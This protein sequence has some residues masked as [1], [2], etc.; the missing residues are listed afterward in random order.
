MDESHTRV[1]VEARRPARR[2]AP[3]ID[4]VGFARRVLDVL[5]P[6]RMSVLVRESAWTLEVVTGRQ[7][8][9]PDGWTW[10]EVAIPPDA[11]REHIALTLAT[12]VGKDRDPTLLRTLLA[13]SNDYS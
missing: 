1:I 7:W 4:G 5:R 2:G 6:A 12:L 11:T 8:N 9:R 10:A 3:P 13:L